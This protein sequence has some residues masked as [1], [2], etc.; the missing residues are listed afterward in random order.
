M[1]NEKKSEINSH[2]AN[3]PSE[4]SGKEWKAIGKR[5][6]DQLKRD[7]VQITAAGVAFYFF[8]ALFPT[9]VAAISLYNLVL[10]PS[11]IS[12]QMAKLQGVVP[13]ETY[14]IFK[15]IIDPLLNESSQTLGWS[16]AVSI[17]LSLWSANKGTSAIFE[18]VNIAYNQLDERGFIKKKIMT[19]LFT[20]GGIVIGI[21]SIAAVIAFPSLIN[22]LG[23]STFITGILSLGRWVLMAGI[24]IFSLG[25]LYKFAPARTRARFKWVNWGAA[26]ATVLWLTGSILFS[27]Y[28]SNFG[29][30]S[31]TYGSF[32][33]VIIML[34][35]LFLTAFIILIGAEINS[36]M[37]HQTKKDSTIGSPK[38]MGERGAWHADHVAGKS[39]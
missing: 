14:S 9:I 26:A 23:L 36:E 7:H 38:P 28:V 3:K 13:P 18:G 16:F 21:I 4:F 29:S 8:M 11:Q 1:K 39:N 34:L 22:K 2:N 37:E 30:Y 20:L 6:I 33:A 5:V 25:I 24:L 12:E 32:A 19:L 31:N 15:S 35:W 10:E 17:L 27:W